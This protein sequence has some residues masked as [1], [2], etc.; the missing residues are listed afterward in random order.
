M[1]KDQSI[2]SIRAGKWVGVVIVWLLSFLLLHRDVAG[3]FGDELT[4]VILQSPE[5]RLRCWWA[6]CKRGPRQ[7]EHVQRLCEVD[8]DSQIVQ[9]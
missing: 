2:F 4:V 1:V 3:F 6:S 7:R 5:F 8:L 9:L